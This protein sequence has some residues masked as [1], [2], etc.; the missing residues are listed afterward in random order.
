LKFIGIDNNFINNI[1]VAQQLREKIDKWDNMKLKSFCRA[2]EMVTRVKRLLTTREKIF[3]IYIC[4]KGLMFRIYR[5]LKTLKLLKNKQL[6][7]EMG[8]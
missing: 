8:K 1:P 4:D 5:K 7:E 2:E 6:S 3:A